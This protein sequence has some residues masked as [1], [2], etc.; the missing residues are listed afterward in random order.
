[1][2]TEKAVTA[3]L[4]TPTEGK[5]AIA[6]QTKLFPNGIPECGADA[7]RFTLCSHNLKSN[8]FFYYNLL[9]KCDFFYIFRSF[10]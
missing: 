2:E 9:E 1:M 3:G 6:D 4:L 10:Y 5:K 7:L 8:I